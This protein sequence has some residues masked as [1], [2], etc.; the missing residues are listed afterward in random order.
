MTIVKDEIINSGILMAV[1]AIFAK[2][3]DLLETNLYQGVGLLVL[4]MIALIV[5]SILRQKGYN[6]GSR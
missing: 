3:I 5:R 1:M 6:I 4:C 2:G